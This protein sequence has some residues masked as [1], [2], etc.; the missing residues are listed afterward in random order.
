M[1]KPSFKHASVYIVAFLA[2][3]ICVVGYYVSGQKQYQERVAYANATEPQA[4][5]ELVNLAQQTKELY[6]DD[7][8]ELLKKETTVAD[9]SSLQNE[10]SQ[11]KVSA[12]DFQIEEDSLPKGI[13]KLA[14][15]KEKI[16][17][18]LVDINDKLH[19][20]EQINGFF[21]DEKP[22]WQNFEDNVVAKED[23][24]Q[25]E[26]ADVAEDL[27][28]FEDD[29]WLK[30]AKS[31]TTSAS[32]QLQNVE[33]I[34][35]NLNEYEDEEITY[36]Q[37]DSLV[38]QIEQVRNEKQQE[39]FEKAADDLG[40]HFGVSSEAAVTEST[41]EAASVNNEEAFTEQENTEAY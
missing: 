6:H 11:V 26:I 31:Y 39:K 19:M 4:K 12:E 2:L 34:Q 27:S 28:L 29:Q 23:L 7:K 36:D 9:V 14:K 13:Q 37:Y 1:G 32:E 16:R 25:E 41:E 18:N 17:N 22:V 20:Q 3:G 24:E 5:N 33:E 40:Q 8:Q 38:A 10:V 35:K 21:N 15:E 30:L